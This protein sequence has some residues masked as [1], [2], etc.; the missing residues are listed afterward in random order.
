MINFRS[1]SNLTKVVIPNSV[2]LSTKNYTNAFKN[3]RNLVEVQLPVDKITIMRNMFYN[4]ASLKAAVCGDKVTD[5]SQAYRNCTNLTTAVCGDKVT[6]MSGAYQGCT[7]LT[8]AVCG[9]NVTE[10]GSSYYNCTNLTTAVCGPNVTN[11]YAAYYGCTNLTTAV[12]GPNVTQL[13]GAY[14]HCTNLTTAVCGLNVTN[15]YAAYESCTNLTT[16]VCGPNVT[17]MKQAYNNCRNIR[18]NAYFY[19]NNLTS[20]LQCFQSRS[21]SNRFNIYVHSGTTTHTTVLTDKL[22]DKVTAITWTDDTATNGCHYNTYH[23]IYIY[24]VANVEAVRIANGDPD[25][26]GNM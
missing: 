17:N 24:P 9:P 6:N 10:L 18:G 19:S 11:M 23:N 12:C 7:N 2:Q 1:Y 5:L 4:C 15:M 16:A 8:T 26:M 20:A 3:M 25:Y 21:S 13:G 14:R 22:V